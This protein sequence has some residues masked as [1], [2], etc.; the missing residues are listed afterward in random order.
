MKQM[1]RRLTAILLALFQI[2]SMV[3][4]SAFAA[5][6]GE[7]EDIVSGKV[8]ATDGYFYVYVD[9]T[10]EDLSALG[11]NDYIIVKR[12]AANQ[13]H[14]AYIPLGNITGPGFCKVG[15]G[16]GFVNSDNNS[17]GSARRASYTITAAHIEPSKG[18]APDYLDMYGAEFG[19][20]GSFTS[21]GSKFKWEIIQTRGTVPGTSVRLVREDGI[22]DVEISFQN[23]AGQNK[24]APRVDG[25]YYLIALDAGED[26]DFSSANIASRPDDTYWYIRKLS[27]FDGTPTPT[28][29]Q[30]PGFSNVLYEDYSADPSHPI[31]KAY[32]ELPESVKKNILVRLV[33]ST[34]EIQTF[35]NL[36]QWAGSNEV[37]V[38]EAAINHSFPNYEA[39]ASNGPVQDGDVDY[40]IGFRER[41]AIDQKVTVTFDPAAGA[42]SIPEAEGYYLLAENDWR[43]NHGNPH[44]PGLVQRPDVLLQLAEHYRNRDPEEQRSDD[45]GRRLQPGSRHLYRGGRHRQ[46]FL[47]L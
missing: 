24:E 4:P 11:E 5:A 39:L 19:S 26:G 38:Y 42:V 18:S 10:A 8:N 41:T 3:S 46:Q 44:G 27:G 21:G 1:K 16:D 9:G 33:H 2:V 7:T 15:D 36:K 29:V 12:T 40:R 45:R 28:V 30:I 23:E 22:F 43:G 20:S 34:R 14:Y 6:E 32:A 25:Y 37:T 35:G 47:Y 31:G 13:S 17:M